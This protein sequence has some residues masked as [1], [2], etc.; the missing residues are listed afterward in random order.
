M[1]KKVATKNDFLS[2]ES[3]TH[4]FSYVPYFIGPL[5][6]FFLANTNKK[7]LMTHIKY[8]AVFAIVAV[9]LHVFISGSILGWLVFPVYIVV[10]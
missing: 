1:A 2:Q 9:L 4:A 3:F 8:A 7:K 10:S 5:S 6:M